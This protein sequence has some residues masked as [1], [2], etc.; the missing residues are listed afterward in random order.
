MKRI[1]NFNFKWIFLVGIVILFNSCTE[2]EEEPIKTEIPVDTYWM[3]SSSC[4][5]DFE[6][7]FLNQQSIR[8]ADREGLEVINSCSDEFPEIDFDNFFLLVTRIESTQF[9]VFRGQGLFLKN[10][11]ELVYE[12][13]VNISDFQT[14]GIIYC[15]GVIPNDF[16]Q[17]E[18]KVQVYEN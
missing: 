7:N 4:L 1:E 3:Y 15:F 11:I 12:I 16:S 8:I 13:S 17:N 2:T 5:M 6:E 9:P 14:V 10:D 18:I